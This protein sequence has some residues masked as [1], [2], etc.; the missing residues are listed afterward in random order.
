MK[1]DVVRFPHKFETLHSWRVAK[2]CHHLSPRGE[3]VDSN[4]FWNEDVGSTAKDSQVRDV[5][6]RLVQL[7]IGSAP[8]EASYWG[9]VIDMNGEFNCEFPP[10]LR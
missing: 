9:S 3:F 8:F 2:E 6:L 5:R 10:A 1:D 4:V 7:L